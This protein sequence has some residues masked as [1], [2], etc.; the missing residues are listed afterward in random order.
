MSSTPTDLDGLMCLI[1]I[2]ISESETTCKNSEDD[3]RVGNTAG[4]G[5]LYTD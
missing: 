4:Q 1:T 2:K 3:E 5:S